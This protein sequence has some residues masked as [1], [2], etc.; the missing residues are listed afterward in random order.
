MKTKF[1]KKDIKNWDYSSVGHIKI[2]SLKNKKKKCIN[3]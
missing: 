3:E 2:F 1:V